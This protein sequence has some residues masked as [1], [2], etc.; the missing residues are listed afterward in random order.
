MIVCLLRSYFHFFHVGSRSLPSSA[1]CLAAPVT[2]FSADVT[3]KASVQPFWIAAVPY[4]RAQRAASSD[5][6]KIGGSLVRRFCMGTNPTDVGKAKVAVCDSPSVDEFVGSSSSL[7]VIVAT[8]L[9]VGTFPAVTRSGWA[10]SVSVSRCAVLPSGCVASAVT[11]CGAVFFAGAELLVSIGGILSQPFGSV[12]RESIRVFSQGEWRFGARG[13]I[14]FEGRF[15]SH[16]IRSESVQQG[17]LL[18]K[19]PPTNLR[20]PFSLW[21][22]IFLLFRFCPI[23]RELALLP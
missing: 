17:R 23:G 5:G 11:V 3:V 18:R 6:A 19:I 1:H 7:D 15:Q 21:L 4:V 13:A 14:T 10:P 12:S 20:L 8:V 2:K 16:A 22:R 9:W